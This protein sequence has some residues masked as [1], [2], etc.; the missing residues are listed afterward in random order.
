MP[1][2]DP[3]LSTTHGTFA[4]SAHGALPGGPARTRFFDGMV[5]TQA[6]LENEQRY[7][8]I[9]RR[10][11]NRAL[12]TGVVW[13][14]RLRWDPRRRLFLLAPGYALD[15][16]GNDLIVECPVE[17]AES[18]L[19]ARA[20]PSLRDGGKPSSFEGATAPQP[21]VRSACVVLQYAECPEDAR[22]VHLNPCT[23]P[24]SRCEP[25]RIRETSR[26][27]LVP[28]PSA[29]PP[30][31]IDDFF[32]DLEDIKRSITD[33]ALRDQL[34]P[35]PPPQ[36]QFP[37]PE[38]MLPATL[39]VVTPGSGTTAELTLD[40]PANG[41]VDGSVSALRAIPEGALFA[42]VVQFELRPSPE[43]GF[44]Q[45]TVREG[46]A[47]G[48]V[49]DMVAPP[50]DL[51]QFWS[52]EIVLPGDVQ[53]VERTFRYEV[54]QLGLEQMFGDRATGI[55]DLV[56]TGTVIVSRRSD[57]IQTTLKPISIESKSSVGQR[58]GAASCFD[59]LLPW[60]FMAD[61]D[62]AVEHAK[63][64]MLAALYAYFSDV[65]ARSGGASTRQR[66]VAATIY[67]AAWGLLGVDMAA[68][69]AEA[70]KLE[71][72]R[73]LGRLFQCWCD[74]MLYPGP[75]CTS[76]HHGVYLGCATVGPNGQ[77]LSFDMWEHRRHVLTGPLI[78]HWLGVFRLAPVDVIAARLAQAICC[79]AG[80]PLPALPV[81]SRDWLRDGLPVGHGALFFKFNASTEPVQEVGGGE[82]VRRMVGALLADAEAPLSRFRTRLAN[83]MFVELVAPGERKPASNEGRLTAAIDKALARRDEPLRPLASGAA[84]IATAEIA[85][86]VPPTALPELYDATAELA[87]SLGETG[88]TLAGLIE[89]GAAELLTAHP[90]ADPSAIDD[91]SARAEAALQWLADGVAA[92]I[93]KAEPA[94]PSVM[95]RNAAVR[96]AIAAELRRRFDALTP[97][98]VDA[99]LERAAA[100][101]P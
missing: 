50:L 22:P 16:C 19:L 87:K 90:E 31:C 78:N 28:P 32:A 2:S 17:V 10:L 61:R 82:I 45:G 58:A 44:F 56:I 65:T 74:A 27:L 34:F 25:S 47:G 40:L 26:L 96:E 62:D 55:A 24:T 52:L 54:G 67:A 66:I 75:R 89:A 38:A 71:L 57:G 8:R 7:W 48:V 46:G 59:G 92:G 41:H 69:N 1:L 72:T 76:A 79:V 29:P 100:R 77:I 11:T 88:M 84:R 20:D 23:P 85:R 39:R 33:P 35:P 5:L 12:G 93:Q 73:L 37:D 60:G 80:L 51:Q 98:Q 15:C 30:D 42:G 97:G 43:W 81:R 99:A 4:A 101:S 91:L 36:Q 49:V 53:E 9:K 6:D 14:L 3:K 68:P 83:G 70:Q 86:E 18:D 95:L 64:L 13:G 21:G 63:L 94:R